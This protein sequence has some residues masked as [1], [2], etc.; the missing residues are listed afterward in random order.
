MSTSKTNQNVD[1]RVL[2]KGASPAEL[3]PD[4]DQD[5]YVKD[6]LPI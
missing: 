2:L 3:L 1:A 5:M 6:D 4:V